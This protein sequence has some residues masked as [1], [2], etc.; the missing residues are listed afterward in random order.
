VILIAHTSGCPSPVYRWWIGTVSSSNS[1]DIA[2]LEGAPYSASDT[3]TWDTTG[4]APGT[5]LVSFWAENAGESGDSS[6]VAG[7]AQFTV[8]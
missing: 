1:K 8:Q 6:D 4:L 2:W 3:Y 7:G 5:Y